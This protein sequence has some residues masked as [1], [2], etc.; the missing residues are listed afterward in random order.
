MKTSLLS[1][2]DRLLGYHHH[3]LSRVFAIRRRTYQ[4]CVNCGREFAYSWD[5]M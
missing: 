5:L 2:M 4:V 3:Q 1:L